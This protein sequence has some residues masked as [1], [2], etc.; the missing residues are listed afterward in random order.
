VATLRLVFSAVAAF[1]SAVAAGI[2]LVTWISPAALGDLMVRHLVLLMLIE[3]LVVHSTPFMGS[4]VMGKHPRRVKVRGL[5]GFGIMYSAFA[6]GFALSF[7]RWWPFAVIWGLVLNKMLA[8]WWAGAPSAKQND[9]FVAQWGASAAFYLLAI[10]ITTMSPMPAFGITSSVRS[11]QD[12][13]GT[14]LWIDEPHRVLAAGFLYFLA[15][16]ITH[17]VLTY[18]TR[19]P[20]LSWVPTGTNP[21]REYSPPA[22]A[23][24]DSQAD[25]A[26]S[27]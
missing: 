21:S 2:F 1:P 26:N 17:F 23:S 10:G 13:P 6:A 7:E 8:A 12:L 24:V 20:K 18:R 25:V 9:L 27:K 15:M 14:G 11:A 22:A 5:L 3:F 19:Q 16:A 4:V